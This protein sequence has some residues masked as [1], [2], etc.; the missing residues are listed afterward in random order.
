MFARIRSGETTVLSNVGIA[1]E[2]LDIPELEVAILA[3]PTKSQ[4]LHMQM[5]GRVLRPAPGK[6]RALILDHADCVRRRGLGRPDDERDFTLDRNAKFDRTD[7]PISKTCPSCNA[8]VHIGRIL[9]PHCEFDFAKTCQVCDVHELGVTREKVRS[10]NR[11]LQRKYDAQEDIMICRTC[12]SVGPHGDG[13]LVEL[14]R[15]VKLAGP[16][17][18]AQAATLRRFGLRDDLAW[19]DA[20]R[21]IVQLAA[22]G[23]KLT[24]EMTARYAR[25]QCAKNA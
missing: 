22:R 21:V 10:L 19:Q 16:C 20:Q 12:I 5:L 8:S 17:S 14:A 7:D 4:C 2:G 9:C 6:T 13:E 23:W 24:P 15:R 18:G 25:S 11:D 3:R 1:T